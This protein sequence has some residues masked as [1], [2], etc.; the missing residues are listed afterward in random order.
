M[1]DKAS[2]SIKTNNREE[3]GASFKIMLTVVPKE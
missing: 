2:V 3:S 1:E